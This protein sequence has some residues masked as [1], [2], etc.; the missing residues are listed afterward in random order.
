MFVHSFFYIVQKCF[1]PLFSSMKRMFYRCCFTIPSFKNGKKSHFV[2]EIQ[3]ST[4]FLPGLVESRISGLKNTFYAGNTGV[5]RNSGIVKNG[6]IFNC[7]M[8]ILVALLRLGI[9]TQTFTMIAKQDYRQI[10]SSS[11]SVLHSARSHH[12]KSYRFFPTDSK[13]LPLAA[14]SSA[15][16]RFCRASAGNTPV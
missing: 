5:K 9:P 14:T 11:V 12:Q 4:R 13:S 3:D 10:N 15:L 8:P 7:E 1:Q 2:P 6:R 16:L